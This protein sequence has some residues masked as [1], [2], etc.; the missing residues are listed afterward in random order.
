MFIGMIQIIET[1][2]FK[3][4]WKRGLLLIFIR[5]HQLCKPIEK[6]FVEEKQISVPE[7][8]MKILRK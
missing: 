6:L 3:T 7:L 2:E 5:M 4:I 1:L 8:K